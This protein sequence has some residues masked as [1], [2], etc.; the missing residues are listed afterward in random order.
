M[1]ESVTTRAK[2]QRLLLAVLPES[3]VDDGLALWRSIYWKRRNS[4]SSR[5]NRRTVARMIETG[6]PIRLE[7]GSPKREG[8]EN[9]VATD[10]NGGGDLK[11]DFTR[12]LPFPDN[13]VQRIYS[14]HVLEHLSYPHP[15]VDFLRECRRILEPGG[16]ISI[17]V[18]NARIFLEGYLRPTEFDIARYCTHDVGLAYKSRIDV[19]NFI[20]YMGGDHKHMFDEQSLQIILTE[21][22]FTNVSLRDFDGRLDLAARRHESIYAAGIK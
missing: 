16:E 14:S 10:I 19:V 2:V 21:A 5:K 13:S 4:I 6:E 18:P 22:G 20:A 8:M 11:V 17:A 12:P 3:V 15:M 7:L 9:W 1:A